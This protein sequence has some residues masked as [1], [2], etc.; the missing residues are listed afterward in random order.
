MNTFVSL[1]TLC[2]ICKQRLSSWRREERF[3]LGIAG[4]P[5]V[6]KTTLAEALCR[7]L[8][9]EIQCVV[10]PMDGFHLANEELQKR[11]LLDRK[12]SPD[13]FAADAFVELL[14]AIG[15]RPRSALTFPIYSRVLHAPLMSCEI[16]KKE[17]D[18]VIVEGN[19]LLLEFPPWNKIASV[20]EECWYLEGQ[21]EILLQRLMQ[22][23][24]RAG[25]SEAEARVHVQRVDFNNYRLIERSKRRAHRI[26]SLSSNLQEG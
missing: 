8:S 23:Q 3:I 12:G 4:P 17:T 10:V 24:L 11:G 26:L 7:R 22:R 13:T 21:W 15:R 9:N 25:T 16:V 20:L 5:G 19:Y 1:E 2:S 6:G 18:L 14:T